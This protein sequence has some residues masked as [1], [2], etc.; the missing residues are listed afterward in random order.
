MKSY[1]LIDHTANIGIRAF[2]QTLEQMFAHMALGMFGQ[3]VDLSLVTGQ[4][5]KKIIV[6]AADEEELLVEWLNELLYLYLVKKYAFN[7]FKINKILYRQKL[8]AEAYGI[9]LTKKNQ[10][11][12]K[13]KEIK[14]ATYHQLK[15][16]QENGVYIGEV[17]FNV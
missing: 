9:K 4:Q 15:I 13:K 3:M 6:E 5:K 1:E 10:T 12:I 17:L 7:I 2:G 16:K 14:A 11:S 8:E